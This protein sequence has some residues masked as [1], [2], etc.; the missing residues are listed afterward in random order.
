MSNENRIL[1]NLHKLWEGTGSAYQLNLKIT[2]YTDL[3]SMNTKHRKKKKKKIWGYNIEWC[4]LTY[5]AL[6]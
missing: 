3:N 1:L 6:L 2:G 5:F 4:Y